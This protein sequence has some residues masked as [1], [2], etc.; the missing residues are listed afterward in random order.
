MYSVLLMDK[1]AA[2]MITHASRRL[3]GGQPQTS[4]FYQLHYASNRL[5][6]R[7]SLLRGI[8]Y[9]FSYEIKRL[10]DPSNQQVVGSA[11]PI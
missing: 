1:S 7:Y 9:N 10:L 6:L 2:G 8:L 5:L 3:V 11:S 4:S